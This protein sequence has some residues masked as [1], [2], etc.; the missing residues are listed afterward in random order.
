MKQLFHLIDNALLAFEPINN[1]DWH[2]VSDA[3]E[4]EK[5]LYS[6]TEVETCWLDLR[7]E[8]S[9]I[10]KLTTREQRDYWDK[11]IV[12]IILARLKEVGYME[13]ANDIEADLFNCHLN[14]KH[15]QKHPLWNA[16]FKAYKKGSF[17]CGWLG[18]YSNGKL[19]VFNPNSHH[20]SN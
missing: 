2:I 13:Y 9:L 14:I 3:T 20:T 11:E 12:P 8:H 1:E 5:Y 15:I 7:Q 6:Q 16:V 18:D 10:F 17:P 19:V 4:M